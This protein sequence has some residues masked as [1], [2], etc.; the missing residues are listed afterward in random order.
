M[1]YAAKFFYTLFFK[2]TINA[3]EESGMEVCYNN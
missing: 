3:L 2:E 1:G